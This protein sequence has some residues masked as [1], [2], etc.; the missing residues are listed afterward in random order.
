MDDLIKLL[1]NVEKKPEL[2]IG[3]R[4]IRSLRHFLFGYCIGRSLDTPGYGEWLFGDF[5]NYL[6]ALYRDNRSFDWCGLIRA[7]EEDGGST[8]AFFRL[9]DSFLARQRSKERGA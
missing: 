9:L 6:A 4:D 1:R 7:N 2:F 8:D 5:R 3:N